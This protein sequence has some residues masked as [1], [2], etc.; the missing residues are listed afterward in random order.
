M[1]FLVG[2]DNRDGRCKSITGAETPFTHP[3][4]LF[5]V[6]GYDNNVEGME[7]TALHFMRKWVQPSYTPVVLLCTVN[8][9]G[10]STEKEELEYLQRVLPEDGNCV[11]PC[12]PP[13]AGR[14]DRLYNGVD[15]DFCKDVLNG[16]MVYRVIFI[17][18]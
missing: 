9:Y 17:S 10:C 11:V 14:I 13:I 12:I 4:L 5:H 8:I 15:R 18:K 1:L 16:G 6:S 3:Y 7:K 2:V